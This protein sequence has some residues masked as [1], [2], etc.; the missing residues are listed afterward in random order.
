[1]VIGEQPHSV[2]II[3]IIYPSAYSNIFFLDRT[4]KEVQEAIVLNLTLFTSYIYFLQAKYH[5]NVQKKKQFLPM[6]ASDLLDGRLLSQSSP[7]M[8][9]RNGHMYQV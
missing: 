4:V 2:I 1:M 9:K 6:V 5:S 3:L 7:S 8:D